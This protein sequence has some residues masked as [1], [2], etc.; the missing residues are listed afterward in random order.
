[1]QDE[2]GIKAHKEKSWFER[3]SHI[4]IRDPQNREEL[5]DVLREC[6]E[7]DVLGKDA[8]EMIEGVLAVSELQ[9]RDVMVPRPH[10]TVIDSDSDLQ[11]LLPTIIA[12]GHSRF[13]VVE[14]N[15]DEVI[16][17]L[18]AKDLLKYFFETDKKE[19]FHLQ[20][21]IRPAIFTPESKRVDILL[22]EFRQNR[23]HMAIVVDEYGGV[24]GL[25]TIEDILEEIV[26][27]IADEHDATEDI[28]ITKQNDH[29]YTVKGLTPIDEFNDFFAA[30]LDEEE[31]DTI[32]GLVMHSLG[33]M[34]KDEETVTIDNFHFRVLHSEK[35]RIQLLEVIISS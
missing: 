14:E 11:E 6:A 29:T 23:N 28:C 16:G 13:P 34:P 33:H 35:R 27:E 25:V 30:Q 9:V 12:S 2:S 18:F 22:K 24:S 15:K 26:G 4:L 21:F 8:L 10:M 20:H 17:I 32:G 19:A 31:F 5:I 1:M 7:E 3:L